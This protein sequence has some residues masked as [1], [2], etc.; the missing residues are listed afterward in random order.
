[1]KRYHNKSDDSDRN[2]FDRRGSAPYPFLCGD[3]VQ[4]E[5]IRFRMTTSGTLLL[6][7]DERLE[8]T[9]FRDYMQLAD[10]V[11]NPDV[12]LF[13]AQSAIAIAD[14]VRGW[15]Q[16]LD[17]EPPELSYII[18][19]SSLSYGQ[20]NR[21]EV[22]RHVAEEAVRLR[23]RY[24]GAKALIV[25]Q[26][27]YTG[28]TLRL[29]IETARQAEIEVVGATEHARWYEE[30]IDTRAADLENM[31]TTHK[32]FMGHIGRQAAESDAYDNN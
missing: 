2:L 27:V 26:Y 6:P 12:M 21:P 29:A 19:N 28:R 25:D 9:S 10:E 15:H 18:A 8:N 13:T 1:M 24:L 11:V 31:T 20:I 14:A 4:D 5:E 17:T 23:K 22:E 16:T 7:N 3:D 30:L 32:G